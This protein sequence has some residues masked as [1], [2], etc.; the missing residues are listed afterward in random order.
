MLSRFLLTMVSSWAMNPLA[1]LV[2]QSF[3]V[4]NAPVVIA[5]LLAT[6]ACV[7]FQLLINE[8]I[9]ATE[10]RG[11]LRSTRRQL[12]M[13]LS[14]QFAACVLSVAW[15]GTQNFPLSQIVLIAG[16]LAVSTGFSYQTSVW[17][18]RLAMTSSMCLKMS[19]MV[20]AIPGITSLLLYFAYCG[21]S[22]WQSSFPSDVFVVASTVL[23]AI[24]Q[25]RY[26]QNLSLHFDTAFRPPA[27]ES[28]PA[29]STSW[30]IAAA[31]VLAA[32][33]A[34]ST[35]LRGEIAFFRSDY[36]AVVLVVLNSLLSPINTMTRAA[37]LNQPRDIYRKW[38]TWSVIGVAALSAITFALGSSVFL[39]LALLCAQLAVASVIEAARQVP[40]STA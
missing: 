24:V 13:L 29:P 19:V 1:I 2:A 17:Y 31:V 38:L 34:G 37:F 20:G 11:R 35:R 10:T 33:T 4:A 32:L 14:V 28:P 25:R 7:P 36:V 9:A 40:I 8:C 16:L 27:T 5:V 15:L 23:P 39:L 26:V 21:I 3:G 22:P 18:F 30:L 6:G 12:V